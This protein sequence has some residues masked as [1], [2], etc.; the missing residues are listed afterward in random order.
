MRGARAKPKSAALRGPRPV[1]Y[2]EQGLQARPAGLGR[3]L[4]A[5]GHQHPVVA[6]EG[7]HVGAGAQGHQVQAVAQVGLRPAL[8]P[9]QAA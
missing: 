9:P 4:Y 1:G 7:H 6:L 2:L 8:E 5:L 3:D